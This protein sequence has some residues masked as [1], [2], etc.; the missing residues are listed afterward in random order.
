MFSTTATIADIATSPGRGALGVVR[1][2]GPD[3]PPIACA[4]AGR[5]QP[6]EPRL[7]TF[8]RIVTAEGTADEVLL[9]LLS[10]SAVLHRRRFGRDQRPRQPRRPR[11][12]A[13]CGDRARGP[14]RAAGEFTFRAFVNGR[15]DL[16]QAEAVADLV[17]AVTPRQARAA[18]EQLEGGLGERI[19]AF[20]ERLFDLGARL[21]AS[22]D[23][24]DEGYHFVDP[25][26]VAGEVRALS[27]GIRALLSTA[28]QG[29]ILRE[30]PP[31]GGGRPEEYR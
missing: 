25:S 4:L 1:I 12:P 18:F 16:T 27:E 9:T 17:D 21:E 19:H 5:T 3:A 23:F 20:D 13:A 28:A 26:A 30:G 8:A 31:G 6:L 7:A 2:S 14:A 10:R 22:L 29:R 24:P 15:I 11:R